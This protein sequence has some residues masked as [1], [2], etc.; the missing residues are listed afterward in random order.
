MTTVPHEKGTMGMGESTISHTHKMGPFHTDTNDLYDMSFLKHGENSPLNR[1]IYIHVCK[2]SLLK[3]AMQTINTHYFRG[4]SRQ[5][6]A[7]HTHRLSFLF[8]HLW[9]QGVGDHSLQRI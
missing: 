5:V 1:I 4:T 9:L 2:N 3:Q 6:G 8:Y 7:T